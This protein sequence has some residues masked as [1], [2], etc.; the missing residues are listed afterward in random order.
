MKNSIKFCILFTKHSY[1]ARKDS[2][3][4]FVVE[5]FLKRI[6]YAEDATFSICR[7]ILIFL[8]KK[9]SKWTCFLDN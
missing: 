9:T 3:A 4:D 2:V 7:K 1:V 6:R 5:G 8:R